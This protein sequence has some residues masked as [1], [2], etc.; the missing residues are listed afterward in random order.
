MRKAAERSLEGLR[1]ITFVHKTA[2]NFHNSSF[3]TLTSKL[4]PNFAVLNMLPVTMPQVNVTNK[5]IFM[6]PFQSDSRLVNQ[7][8][9]AAA[10]QPTLQGSFRL[11]FF[12]KM[13]G[14]TP[15]K[16]QKI[17][18]V[19]LLSSASSGL[20]KL[21]QSESKAL[22]PNSGNPIHPT[23]SSALKCPIHIETEF[24]NDVGIQNTIILTKGLNL[25]CLKTFQKRN[26]FLAV[27][28]ML[29]TNCP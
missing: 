26:G 28:Q 3:S 20:H 24:T 17:L 8:Y 14:M 9:T 22:F 19:R 23:Y 10:R 7:V 5:T 25:N 15:Q 11:R 6:S 27:L 2:T 21:L 4:P 29:D 16:R 18:C 1:V 13:T 12:N